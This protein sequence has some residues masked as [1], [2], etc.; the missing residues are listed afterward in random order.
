[1][2][3]KLKMSKKTRNLLRYALTLFIVTVILF[4]WILMKYRIS[5][6]LVWVIFF[7]YGAL[8][9]GWFYVCVNIAHKLKSLRFGI[10]L[11]LLGLSLMF[12]AFWYVSAYY[13]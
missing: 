8:Y 13:L 2:K 4:L 6:D 10:V 11:F 7:L 1:M 5:S 12:T 9:A 3:K